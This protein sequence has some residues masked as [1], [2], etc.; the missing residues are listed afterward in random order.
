MGQRPHAVA[1]VLPRFLEPGAKPSVTHF[2]LYALDVAELESGD[3]P[4]ERAL[5]RFE[6]GVKLARQGSKALDAVE[7]RVEVLLA[8]RDEAVALQQEDDEEKS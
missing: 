2:F 1:H 6:H 7:E 5:E 3:L 4:L 8:E